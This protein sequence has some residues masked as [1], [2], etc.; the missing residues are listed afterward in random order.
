MKSWVRHCSADDP[1]GGEDDVQVLHRAADQGRQAD[2]EESHEARRA[3]GG[4]DQTARAD[5]RRLPQRARTARLHGPRITHRHR[6][7]PGTAGHRL[8]AALRSS[9]TTV[10]FNRSNLGIMHALNCH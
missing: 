3:A 2:D 4:D 5:A 8:T 9:V 1:R 10:T 7:C 6:T